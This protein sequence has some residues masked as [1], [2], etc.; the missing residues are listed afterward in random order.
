MVLEGSSYAFDIL[1]HLIPGHWP[2]I[3]YR[4]ASIARSDMWY[5]NL[6]IVRCSSCSVCSCQ[7]KVYFV[8]MCVIIIS[9]DILVTD[10]VQV[11]L[12]SCPQF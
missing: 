10:A 8:I 4:H 5:F 1:I 3:S 6:F 9:I 12:L 11:K 2:M 7:F